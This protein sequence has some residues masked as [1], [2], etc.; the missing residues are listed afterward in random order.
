[1]VKHIV[2]F[3]LKETLSPAEKADIMNRFKAAIE[4]LPATIPFI[5]DIHVGLN[6]NPAEVWDICLDSS[7]DTLDDVK[8]GELSELKARAEAIGLAQLAERCGAGL[9]TLSDIIKELMK[10]GRDIRDELPKPIL[11]TDVLEMKDLKPGM[12]LT[13]TVRNVIDFGVFVDIGVHQDGLVHISQVSK[14]FIRHP[15]EVVSVGDIVQV[16]VLEVDEKK[17]RISL[18]MKQAPK[19]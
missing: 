7:F 5:R 15:S 2:L 12:V 17:K 19:A 10:P 9:P 16:V 13:G 14:K 11:R 3:K 18:S 8:A 4:A 1:M 6:E